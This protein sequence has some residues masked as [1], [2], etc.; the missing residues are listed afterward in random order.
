MYYSILADLIVTLHFLFV[1]F[2]ITGAIL[3]FK[4]SWIIWIHIPVVLWAIYIEFTGQICPLTPLENEL[5]IKSGEYNY[6]GS[7]ID[8][9]LT[10]VLYPEGLTRDIQLILGLVVLAL[11]IV[12]YWRLF[13]TNRR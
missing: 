4:W 7:F 12:I 3:A 11:N 9:Y 5:R 6:T 10:P 2:V 13:T 1:L 8:H